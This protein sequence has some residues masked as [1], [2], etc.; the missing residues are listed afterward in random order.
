MHGQNNIKSVY[1]YVSWS[2]RCHLPWESKVLPTCGSQPLNDVIKHTRWGRTDLE[3]VGPEAGNVGRKFWLS[4]WRR[5]LRAD[6]LGGCWIPV[7]RHLDGDAGTVGTSQ[8]HH[9]IVTA[10]LLV[11]PQRAWQQS[12]RL[13]QTD[14]RT[15]R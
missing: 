8:G 7:L 1:S 4:R 15:E 5:V 2:T 12:C 11:S 6:C 10:R 13:K 14:R 9:L 3:S